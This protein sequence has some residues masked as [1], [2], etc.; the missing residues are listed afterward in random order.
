MAETDGTFFRLASSKLRYATKALLYLA[1]HGGGRNVA[2][3]EIAKERAI[4]EKYLELIV[5]ELRA[6]G[7]LESVKGKHGGYRLAR[8]PAAIRLME[9]VTVLEGSSLGDPEGSEG[10]RDPAIWAE[11]N[12][13]VT[14]LLEERTLADALIAEERRRGVLNYTI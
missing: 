12:R 5:G 6:A 14:E 4:P 10:D 2:T 13:R 9:L 8:R 11:L 3:R 1:E 7:I